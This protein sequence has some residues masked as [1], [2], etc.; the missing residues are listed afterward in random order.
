MGLG[1]DESLQLCS[2]PTHSRKTLRTSDTGG[3]SICH[4]MFLGLMSNHL[5]KPSDALL[6]DISAPTQ[7]HRG[8]G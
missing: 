2:P 7:G 6:E 4:R 5:G 8:M 3:G 1:I